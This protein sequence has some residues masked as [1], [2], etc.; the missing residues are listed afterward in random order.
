MWSNRAS[1]TVFGLVLAL[2]A[3]GSARA[4][5]PLSFS[6]AS[7]PSGLA[8]ILKDWRYGHGAAWGD[9]DG[10]GK[11]DLYVGAFSDRKTFKGDQAP[12]PNMLLLQ[13]DGRFELSGQK[14]LQFAGKG[15]CCSMVLFVDLDNDGDLDLLVGNYAD[16]A[17]RT[18]GRLFE[19]V[20]GGKF[21]D[22]TDRIEPWPKGFAMRNVTALDVNH[23][24]LLDLILADGGNPKSAHVRVLQNKGKF[25]F[26]DVSAAAGFPD[27]QTV[28]LGL[29]AGDV[30]NDGVADIFVVGSN[31]LFL[32]SAGG[33]YSLAELPE[34]LFPKFKGEFMPC[35]AALG[36]LNGDGLLDLVL[37]IHDEPGVVYV[38]LNKG[39]RDGVPE[40]QKVH[41]WEY[42]KGTK[43]RLPVKAA[44]VIICDMDAD[45]RNDIALAIIYKTADGRTQPLVLR[46]E[47]VKDG[48]PQFL[49]PPP[50]T[51]I[52]Y[53]APG[54]MTDYDRDGRIDIFLPSW[55][56]EL[57]SYLFHNDTKGGHWL[58][59]RVAGDGKTFNPMGLGAIVRAY[60]PG[61]A[62]DAK[63][64]I[65]RTDLSVGNGY[66]SGEEAICFLGLGKADNVDL[67]ITWGTAKVVV[68]D[69][70][71]DR[72]MTVPFPGK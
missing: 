36:D 16:R 55:F 52:G 62:G 12:L 39:V 56:E 38:Y 23:D 5:G 24:G 26:Q 34:D 35:G 31:R 70:A 17:G 14:D 1:L 69:V 27:A 29:A 6:D 45:G 65:A 61:K 25:Q 40:F 20:G 50:E 22:V 44:H 11:P 9:V 15:A 2:S 37:T 28:G 51:A 58:A 13:K 42:P 47:G 46:N 3:A 57:P 49:V 33:T 43:D 4:E 59:V 63:A 32:G 60:Q 53:Y 18:D 48:V 30:N 67:E 41:T 8:K 64:L 66:A 10:D 54:P 21:V 19:N 71:V 7:E 68:H 72:Y